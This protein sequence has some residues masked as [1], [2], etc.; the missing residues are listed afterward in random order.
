M[1]VRGLTVALTAVALL[2]AYIFT[3]LD[4]VSSENLDQNKI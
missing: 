2:P 3:L 1:I 4:S